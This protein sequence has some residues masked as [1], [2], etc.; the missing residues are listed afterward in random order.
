VLDPALFSELGLATVLM[1]GVL[2]YRA[3]LKI[4]RL[5]KQPLDY[6]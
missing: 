1:G 5:Y 4:D 3:H 6:C 2:A